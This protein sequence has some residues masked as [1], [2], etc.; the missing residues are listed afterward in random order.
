MFGQLLCACPIEFSSTNPVGSRL[1]TFRLGDYHKRRWDDKS[2]AV[3]WRDM[4]ET[5][6][7]VV[8]WNGRRFD[9]PFL[10]GRLKEY[11]L[12]PVNL[13]RHEDLMFTAR[14]HMRCMGL[15]NSK[16]DT[17][18]KKLRLP[19]QKTPM[20]ARQWIRAIGGHEPSY[21]SIIHHCQHDVK[22]LAGV[23]WKLKHLV[24]EIR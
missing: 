10:D 24:R 11:G 3:A 20:V 13:A 1:Q 8:T 17:V 9:M 22:V 21:R 6:D 2:L 16:L 4:L 5:Y 15:K 19:V 18:A 23:W 12:R 14:H 7:V